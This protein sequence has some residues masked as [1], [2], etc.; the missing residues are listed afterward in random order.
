MPNIDFKPDVDF[1]P[2]KVGDTPTTGAIDFKPDTVDFRPDPE[3]EELKPIFKA[4][5]TEEDVLLQAA[6]NFVDSAGFGIP[7][8]ITKKFGYEIPEPLSPVGRV[9]AG[10]GQLGGF[11]AMP[12][13]IGG[14]IGAKL[15]KPI[16]RKI[17]LGMAIPKAQRLVKTAKWLLDPR[18]AKSKGLVMSQGAISL[19]IASGL[20]TPEEGLFAPEQR[21]KQFGSGAV[22][23][24]IFGGM[25][26]V[27]SRAQRMVANAAIVGGPSTLQGDSLEEQ[28]FNYGLGA[29]F[30]IKG[31]TVKG[32]YKNQLKL[33]REIRGGH[34]KI[35]DINRE[36]D[37]IEG[38]LDYLRRKIDATKP[39]AKTDKDFLADISWSNKP[40]VYDRDGTLM[41]MD[42][43]T[44]GYKAV[45]INHRRDFLVQLRN[46]LSIPANAMRTD[47]VGRILRLVTTDAGGAKG[48]GVF[49]TK[50]IS[51]SK[52][53]KLTAKELDALT[54]E[55]KLAEPAPDPHQT[56]PGGGKPLSLWGMVFQPS[57]NAMNRMGLGKLY[58]NLTG[59][60]LTESRVT[61]ASEIL[62]DSKRHISVLNSL[63]RI[64]GLN[65]YENIKKRLRGEIKDDNTLRKLGGDK[66]VRSAQG[67]RRYLD[68][69]VQDLNVWMAENGKPPIKY[70]K[71][72]LS[73]IYTEFK[74]KDLQ[75][76]LPADVI[77]LT[78]F[79]AGKAQEQKFRFGLERKGKKGEKEE[80]LW[81]ILDIYHR[82]ASHARNDS[83]IR[84]GSKYTEYLRREEAVLTAKGESFEKKFGMP[85]KEL[86]GNIEK[87]I[88]FDKRHPTQIDKFIGQ[89]STPI[90]RWL[91]NIGMEAFQ[92]KSMNDI[93]HQA[94][95][96]FY[97]SQMGLRI[98][99]PIRNLFQSTLPI[100]RVGLR[101]WVQAM[102]AKDTPELMDALQKSEVYMARQVSQL[103]VE[104]G[105]QNNLATKSLGAYKA[106]D[107]F[108]IRKSFLSGY[109]KV[110]GG[111]LA[112][113]GSE[114]QKRAIL[115]GNSVAAE[116][117]WLYL[118]MNRSGIGQLF[119]PAAMF[120]TWSTNYLD[121]LLASAAPEYRKELV[122]YAAVVLGISSVAAGLGLKGAQYT[123]LSS[124]RSVMDLG[125]GKLPLLGV[126]EN[127]DIGFMRDI[128][129]AYKGDLWDAMFYTDQ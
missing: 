22:T 4:K 116:T 122:Q 31:N 54:T 11:I 13:K 70:R 121:F 35:E 51:K 18:V 83:F 82:A 12:A 38:N 108:N 9:G 91:G 60:T 75:D 46:I 23:G 97:A 100:A 80:N 110:T 66:A 65:G 8:Y 111:K 5:S 10:A 47:K 25:S 94:T 29:Y 48:K 85:S 67:I 56:A 15:M 71:D 50:K 52:V 126:T 127:F 81:D 119:A 105:V 1:I 124:L 95:N 115:K 69:M 55:L 79:Y 89:F 7:E 125:R 72:Y 3:P 26:Y 53:D 84:R 68:I 102:K 123:G 120:T 40:S 34:S 93:S 103:P 128:K 43:N 37:S 61:D 104:T 49:G 101:P 58:S 129:K 20:M 2:D 96:L 90:N 114:L 42:K 78:D 24:A 76:I 33:G 74:R 57:V 14:A 28:I 88:A 6:T 21:L 62:I 113:I 118:R 32:T 86:I 36:F 16:V 107:L 117:Q 30:G 98:K 63:K 73:D 44:K 109:F 112:P 39:S 45:M 27:P 19:G 106:S 87:M 92:I 99:L 64:N 77:Q 17:A 59:K 41:S